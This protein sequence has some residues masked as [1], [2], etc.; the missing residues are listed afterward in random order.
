M[1]ILL[2]HLQEDEFLTTVHLLSLAQT[3]QILACFH[4]IMF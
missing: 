4:H 2:K 1:K 3:K